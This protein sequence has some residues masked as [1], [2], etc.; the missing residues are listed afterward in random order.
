[1]CW[2]TKLGHE[3]IVRLL[4]ASNSE[5]SRRL[6]LIAARYGQQAVVRLLLH[7]EHVDTNATDT[8]GR[9]PLLLAANYGHRLMVQLLV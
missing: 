4:L 8:Y 2:A 7:C 3:A 5:N 1:L 6:L 9:T